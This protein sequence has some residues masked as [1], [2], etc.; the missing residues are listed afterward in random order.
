MIDIYMF[1]HIYM[2]QEVDGTWK[3][4]SYRAGLCGTKGKSLPILYM[5]NK[6]QDP[7]DINRLCVDYD[8]LI[9]TIHTRTELLSHEVL[10]YVMEKDEISNQ[11]ISN[12]DSKLAANK[13]LLAKCDDLN[14]EIEKLRQLQLLSRDC[15]ARLQDIHQSLTRLK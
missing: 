15:V 2:Y 10:K 13:T 7:L 5:Q 4:A 14:M 6:L 8:A 11:N 9:K 3:Y 12:L 1:M